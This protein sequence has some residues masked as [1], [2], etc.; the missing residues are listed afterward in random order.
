MNHQTS[1][2]KPRD[3]QQRPPRRT[4]PTGQARENLSPQP[5][6]IAHQ[7]ARPPETR[8][9]EGRV[10]G[11][12]TTDRD[13]TRPHARSR[14]ER[15]PT[16][17][18][19]H[20]RRSTHDETPDDEKRNDD[21][22]RRSTDSG[23]P[24]HAEGRPGSPAGRRHGYH[25]P[26]GH[27]IGAVPLSSE[28][29]QSPQLARSE[30]AAVRRSADRAWL[31]PGGTMGELRAIY[32]SVRP[33]RSA[34][35]PIACWSATSVGRRKRGCIPLGVRGEW[36]RATGAEGARPTA[37]DQP[38]ESPKKPAPGKIGQ[39]SDPPGDDNIG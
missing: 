12:R 16:R 18:D 10:E 31:V 4:T 17:H 34:G 25:R 7:R 1:P 23:P 24:E 19:Q 8:H 33:S 36:G 2:N 6:P 32:H 37:V 5:G 15:T 26:A 30:S 20:R 38:L 22:T 21:R 29:S 13:R 14:N 39:L 27:K 3:S 11:R 9:R 35:R 28:A